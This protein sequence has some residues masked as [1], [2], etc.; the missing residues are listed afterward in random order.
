MRKHAMVCSIQLALLAM[1]APAMAQTTS[2]SQP[3]QLDT[4]QVTGSRIPR[5][6]V[7]GPAPISVINA[8][9]IKA[10]GLTSVPDVLRALS[11][12]N[13]YTQG[14]QNTTGAQSTPGA[15]A[16]DL[17][18]LGPNHTL[19]LINGRRIADFP[20]PLNGKSNFT[21][22]G[23]IPLG[24][25]DRIEVLTGSASAVYGSDAMAGVINFILK[26]STDGTTIDYRYGD[27]SRG[28]GESHDLTLTTGFDRGNFT[29]IV[30]VELINKRP[31]W[32]SDRK[33]QDST[34]D[35]PTERSRLLHLV[36]RRYDVDDDVAMDPEGACAN[37]G[38]L[39]GG[40]TTL[41]ADR[42]GEPYC[43]S[44][45]VVGYRTIVNERKGATAYGSFEYRFN[46]ALSWFADVQLGHQKVKLMTGNGGNNA[47]SDNMGWEFHDPAS[48][49]NNDKVFYN[50]GT[51]HYEIWQRQFSPEEVGG[52]GN[53]MNTTTQ[54]TL[55]VTTGLKGMFGENWNWEAAYNHSQYKADVKMP[56]I[57]ADAANRFFL[58][59]RLGYDADG[60]AIYN[61]DP[62][63]LYTPLTA[64][65]FASFAAMSTFRPEAKND[66]VSF[67]ADNG[68][69]FS[70]PAG[71]VGFA[72]VIEYGRQSYAINPDPL[73]L[74]ADAYYGPQYGD[75]DG[76]R[77]RWSAAGELRVPVTSNL[78]ASLAGRYDRYSFGNRNPGKFTYSAG[79]EW[80]P[81][82]T[83]LVRGSYGTGFRAPDM[84]YL[85]AGDDFYRK[86]ST[87]YYQCRTDE[88]G[89]N[90]G[91]CYDEGDWDTNTLDV[92]AGNEELDVET[93][94]SF[95]AGFV[96][97]PIDGLD[98]AVDYYK[99][100][101]MN[102]VQSQD[103]EV[104]RITEANCRLGVT[105]SGAAV[106]INSPTCVD[107]LARVIRD[108]DGTITSV[109]FAPINIARE[110]TSG[111]DVTANYRLPT[112]RIGN[113]NLSGSYTWARNHTRQQYPGDPTEDMLAVTFVDT[114]MPRVKSNLGVSWDRDQWG[115]SL[116]GN[117][118]G[119]VAN[120]DND[121]WTEATW[122]FNAAAR[123]DITDHLRVSLTVNN[124]FDKM[125]PKDAT[126]AAYPYY[127]TSWF[128]TIG[129]SYFVQVTWK[130]GGKPL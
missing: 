51:G 20:L 58:G 106:D 112:T 30:G 7:E 28:G 67:T 78:E 54:K 129:R 97:S 105:D 35:G 98:L 41:A 122:R 89:F 55:A 5:A 3:Q 32:G 21:D 59:E 113:F 53:R 10:A 92:Y 70:L 121:A 43:G 36:A 45:R 24:M 128:D 52:L 74:T 80:R 1:T 37:L 38:A 79:L 27:T 85:F 17:R 73:A 91:K 6:Q 125:P 103:R 126:W 104:L 72:G 93:S 48:T 39:N 84:H 12:N 88:P 82:D 111:V 101:V 115:A 49:D 22:V 19:V 77:N 29:G 114:T 42:Y 117:Y 130:L 107:A 31:L 47:V 76:S 120:Y 18:G 8:E 102:Q 11:Q 16:V 60:Y 65:Q 119:R 96:W 56:R 66:N 81:F 9:Q 69:L 61:P 57:K 118:L 63:R 44:D 33:A 71:D 62:A 123:Y 127:N 94:K 15:Q 116:F 25:I 40:S 14:Q 34:F 86:V 26:K 75:G 46:D 83:L 95:T 23:N 87:D 108:A 50:A 13:G 68:S 124:L 2:G 109:H 110:E 4:V 99:I 90:N 64:A 100:K